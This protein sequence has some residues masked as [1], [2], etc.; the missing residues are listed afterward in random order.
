[1]K[2]ITTLRLPGAKEKDPEAISLGQK[3]TRGK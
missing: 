3:D 2:K 1:M